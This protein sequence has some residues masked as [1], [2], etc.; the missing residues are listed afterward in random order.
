MIVER[1]QIEGKSVQYLPENP[2]AM[3]LQDDFP[4][5][6]HELS[7][8]LPFLQHKIIASSPQY[9]LLKLQIKLTPN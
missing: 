1:V 3:L 9:H 7:V 6:S 5:F 2:L 8:I 4:L